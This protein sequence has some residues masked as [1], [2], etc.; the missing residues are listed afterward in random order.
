MIDCNKNIL[1]YCL[2]K[3]Y[4][5]NQDL[6]SIGMNSPRA[7]L[8]A[9]LYID[10]KNNQ[11]PILSKYQ[12]DAGEKAVGYYAAAYIAKNIQVGQVASTLKEKLFYESAPMTLTDLIAEEENCKNNLLKLVEKVFNENICVQIKDLKQ[13]T[14]FFKYPHNISYSDEAR[15]FIYDKILKD[16]FTDEE[17]AYF[18]CSD[19]HND[20]Y[21]ERFEV[22]RHIIIERKPSESAFY[23]FMISMACREMSLIHIALSEDKDLEE[24]FH[25]ELLGKLDKKSYAFNEIAI[26]EREIEKGKRASL[27]GFIVTAYQSHIPYFSSSRIDEISENIDGVVRTVKDI[28]F[29]PNIPIDNLQTS[30]EAY[31]VTAVNEIFLMLCDMT[32]TSTEVD[33]LEKL[34]ETIKQYWKPRIKEG[35]IVYTRVDEGLKYAKR[36]TDSFQ[37]IR[38][39]IRKHNK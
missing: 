36:R 10:E 12:R 17:I 6:H 30:D 14:E 16:D 37:H 9:R 22:L 7:W 29:G 39:Y 4:A 15:Q 2:L 21:A 5:A 38:E 31:L 11:I 26:D 8:D 28:Q 13:F 1:T 24:W 34:A 27:T 18:L 33:S 3:H 23:N 19:R 35:Y 32:E 20:N 25:Q